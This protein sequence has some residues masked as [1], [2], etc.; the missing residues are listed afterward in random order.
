MRY[1]PDEE[2]EDVEYHRKVGQKRAK[3][4]ERASKS[5]KNKE[6]PVN[7]FFDDFS[8]SDDEKVNKKS[9][10]SEPSFVLEI[11]RYEDLIDDA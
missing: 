9:E 11:P 10:Q 6:G 7:Y 1:C 3:F 5:L 2:I 4:D 8:E